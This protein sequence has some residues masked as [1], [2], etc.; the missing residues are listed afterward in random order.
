MQAT[1]ASI[2]GYS[3]SDL[4]DSFDGFLEDSGSLRLGSIAVRTCGLP[5]HTPDSMGILVGDSLF[6]G[7]SIFL[8]VHCLHFSME[9]TSLKT[10]S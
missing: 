10:Q 6:A 7:D 1:F 9:C 2:Y 4:K 8:C 3:R 5:G